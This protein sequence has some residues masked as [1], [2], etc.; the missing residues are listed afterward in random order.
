MS[1]V[2]QTLLDVVPSRF[3]ANIE[4]ASCLRPG[5]HEDMESAKEIDYGPHGRFV[6]KAHLGEGLD[7]ASL[8]CT[9]CHHQLT[10]D[11]HITTS[12]ETCN[13]C[14]FTGE[15]LAKGS[16]NCLAC[17]ETPPE[18]IRLERTQATF[19][20]E[21]YVKRDVSCLKCH[22]ESVGGRSAVRKE[23]CVRCHAD[24]E[25][26]VLTEAAELHQAHLAEHK[27]EC[28]ACHEPIEHSRTASTH[29]FAD[30]DTCHFSDRGGPTLMYQ[31]RGGRGV[32]GMPSTMSAAEVDCFSCHT[33]D[34]DTPD[35]RADTHA[36]IK[37]SDAERSCQKCHGTERID[38]LP[39]RSKD[40]AERLIQVES[41]VTAAQAALAELPSDDPD[42]DRLRAKVADARYNLD[43]CRLGNG[44][45]N[46]TY[47]RALMN[48]AQDD[49]AAAIAEI[50]VK[51]PEGMVP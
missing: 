49:A 18:E 11:A 19:V 45:H 7:G 10:D 25:A 38:W 24:Q 50:R 28:S 1:Q 9:T 22:S 31:G 27:V 8:K 5:C 34:A 23:A 20:H 12:P 2:V 51:L 35:Y 13:L 44:L 14:H 21:D 30:C 37:A 17:H 33:P 3:D 42:I 46:Y 6:H 48:R 26:I 32:P 39:K 41:A 16:E 47:F 4:D 15:R 40:M 36:D 29:R 43:F